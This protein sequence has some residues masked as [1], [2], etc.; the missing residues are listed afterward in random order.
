M[1]ELEEV[2]SGLVTFTA[3]HGL[4]SVA[5]I[6]FVKSAGVPLPVP[7]ALFMVLLGVQAS[8]GTV[9]LWLAWLVL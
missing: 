5:A 9:S 1:D 8:E 6:Q 2:W 4:L 7:I 3:S